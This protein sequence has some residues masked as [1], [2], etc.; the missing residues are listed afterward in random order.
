MRIIFIT[1]FGLLFVYQA[2]AQDQS[3]LAPASVEKSIYGI[4]TGFLGAWL[5][6]ESRLSNEFALRSQVGFDFRI[7]GFGEFESFGPNDGFYG[8]LHLSLEPRWYYNLEKRLK[9]GKTID[10]NSGNF[11][12]LL[13]SSNLESVSFTSNDRIESLDQIRFV[14][15]WGI[16]RSLGKHI[17]YEAGFGFGYAFFLNNTERT[18]FFPFRDERNSDF[19]VDI[20]LRIGFDL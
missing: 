18:G 16:R 9:K 20:H 15:K 17:S 5:Y 10:R 12:A 3:N 14:P 4:Q 7:E 1:F 13:V 8:I 11:I 19:T 6:N 2:S